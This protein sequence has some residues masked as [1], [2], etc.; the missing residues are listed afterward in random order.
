VSRFLSYFQ[1]ALATLWNQRVRS[2]LTMLGMVIGS[3]SIIAVFGISRAATS[4]IEA[5]FASFGSLPVYIAVDRSQDHPGRAAMQERDAQSVAAA[6][7]ST[8]IA[9]YPF[10][11]RLYR[12]AFGNVDGY[13]NVAS[14]GGYHNDSLVMAEGRK[15]D[16]ADVDAAARVCVMTAD[17]ARKYFGAQTALGKLIRINGTRYEVVGV[18]ADVKG[19]LLNTLAGSGILIPYTTFYRDFAPGNLDLLEV[20]PADERAADATGKAAIR[21]LQHVH[22]D[23]ARYAVQNGAGFVTAFGGA[24]G[25]VASALSAIGAV[26]LVV[27]GI[28]I[29]NIMLVSVIERTREIGIRKA[30]GASRFEIVAQ[31]LMESVV[32]ALAGGLVGMLLGILATA[33]AISLLS[34][35]LGRMIVPYLLIVSLALSFS[36]AVGTVFGTYPAIRAARLDPIEALRA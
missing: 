27:A 13:E 10:W 1:E 20:Y 29:M 16:D 3:A 34:A 9:V 6:L 32:L 25:I 28:G 19:T 26:A 12:V 14:D 33:G 11:Q 35:E 8:A 18:Y 4:G 36:I 23:R 5:T 30:I 15:L 17:L 24:L 22:G 21:A 31:F 2:A 7:G